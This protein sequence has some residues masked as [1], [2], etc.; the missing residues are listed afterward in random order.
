MAANNP[1]G[2]VATRSD[3]ELLAAA[4]RGD[5]V[6]LDAL[7]IRYQPKLYRFGL[8]MC[9]NVDDAGDVAQ[10]SLIAMA[11]SLRDFRGD[12]SVSS[13]LYTI[14]RRFCMRKRR[15]SMFAPRLEES[16]DA[17]GN[18]VVQRLTDPS[19]DPE[20]A[21]A[22]R[23]VETAL[24]AAIGA[25][26]EGQREVLVLRDIEGLSAPE[27]AKVLGISVDA[28]KSRLHRARVAVR[29]KLAPM[30]GAQAAESAGTGQCPDVLTLFSRHLE[31]EIN[32]TVCAKME[33]HLAQCDRCHGVCETLRRTLALCRQLP[34]PPVPASLAA[35]V[36]TAIRS[37]L[38]DQRLGRS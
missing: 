16:L 20:R 22:S 27:V 18:E 21:A 17:P 11:R 31:G 15:R 36:R 26:D 13:W 33:A 28:V 12:A 3:D 34:A 25:L 8:R 37:F 4:R 5:A 30:W 23:E 38:M 19:P 7:L 9:G 32:P 10:E 2:T 35:S 1:A 6:A 29:N 24:A 14:A